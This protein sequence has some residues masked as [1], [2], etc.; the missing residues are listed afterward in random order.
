MLT[1]RLDTRRRQRAEI[2]HA[3]FSMDLVG[4]LKLDE[5][6][7]FTANENRRTI[8][9]RVFDAHQGVFNRQIQRY[10]AADGGDGL[11]LEGFVP[12]GTDQ[13]DCVIRRSIGIDDNSSHLASSFS[14]INS[15][16]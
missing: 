8:A 11:N 15:F 3:I 12:Q 16:R 4:R 14:T 5:H 13:G 7:L 6:R 2:T 1:L 10:V 9:V